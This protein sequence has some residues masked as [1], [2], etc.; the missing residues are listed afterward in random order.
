MTSPRQKWHVYC[1]RVATLNG[2]VCKM[3]FKVG[4]LA[5]GEN[6][7]CVRNA[8]ARGEDH[9]VRVQLPDGRVEVHDTGQIYER[10]VL[11]PA[12]HDILSEEEVRALARKQ[13]QRSGN[14]SYGTSSRMS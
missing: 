13:H 3:W 8:I 10:W 7:N 4:T 14:T 1:P 12:S 5:R 11:A 6:A 9:G 2:E